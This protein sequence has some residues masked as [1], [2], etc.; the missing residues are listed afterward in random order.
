MP[1]FIIIVISD[2]TQVLIFLVRWPVAATITIVSSRSLGRIDPNSRGGALR[3]ATAGATIATISIAPTL[4][5]VPA[6][7]FG[8]DGLEARK[9]HD[10]CLLRVEQKR[11]LVLDVIFGR[12]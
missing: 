7:S 11:A 1:F 10:L 2:L 3:P 8:L 6:R 9:K 12:F 4:L 5:L